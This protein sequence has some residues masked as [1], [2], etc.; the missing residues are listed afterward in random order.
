MI[1]HREFIL[2][3][4]SLVSI[5][6]LDRASLEVIL[7]LAKSFKQQPNHRVLNNKII[8]T[9]FFEPSTR[10]RLSFETA[11]LRLS[12][13]I[14]GFTDSRST[15]SAKGE[16]LEDTIRMLAGYA[17]CIVVRHP[18]ENSAL[19]ASK[20]SKVPIINAG[21]GSGEHPTQTL[22]DLFSILETQGRI[23]HLVIALTGD[24]KHG[25]TVH[26]LAKALRHY[27]IKLILMAHPGLE[28]P[29]SIIQTC[30]SAGLDIEIRSQWDLSGG[31][32]ILY[33]TRYQ[34]ER[35]SGSLLDIA[36]FILTRTDFEK[37]NT[38]KTLKVMHPLPRVGEIDL[39]VDDAPQ[40]YYF[41]QAENG[42]FVRQA[43]LSLML[44]DFKI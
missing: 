44:S 39:S 40:A 13:Q 20:V 10:T 43:L 14:I 30:R 29:E 33:M 37:F 18:E 1:G 23:D 19:R 25:R 26:S 31:I 3:N 12:G 8:A 5:D 15:S 2:K 7:S 27:K 34:K 6:Q 21:D 16:S 35:W 41:Q 42:L 38:K 36:P 4:K 28:M 9:A 17:D 11:V 24:L 22:L 32:D